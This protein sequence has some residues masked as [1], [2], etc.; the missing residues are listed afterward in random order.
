MSYHRIMSTGAMAGPDAVDGLPAWECWTGAD[1]QVYAR[2]R[3]STPPVVLRG[4]DWA[5][6]RARVQR[7]VLV[8]LL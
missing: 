5:D 6:L 2:L 1:C 3:G 4:A 8:Q 7:Y